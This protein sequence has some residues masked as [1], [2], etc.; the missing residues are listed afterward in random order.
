MTKNIMKTIGAMLIAVAV[1]L[2][3]TMGIT[4]YATSNT[5]SLGASITNVQ[6]ASPVATAT[7]TVTAEEAKEATATETE[8]E[9]EEVVIPQNNTVVVNGKITKSTLDGHY[10]AYSIPGLAVV[11]SLADMQKQAN[12]MVLEYFFVSTWDLYKYTAPAAVE[13]MEIVAQSE[14]AAL[15]ATFQMT[16]S[17][18][19]SM[20]VYPFEND[21]MQ[22]TTKVSIPTA[23]R[24]ENNT[25]AMVCVR[26]GGAFE[27]LPDLDDEP[28]TVTFNAHAG[29][30]AYGIIKY[31][32]K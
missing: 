5:G 4:A 25:Y 7:T 15:G 13:T 18:Y 31:L 8:Q 3:G 16:V 2:S 21:E 29:T 6:E 30:A 32:D 9:K 14:N 23:F 17:R 22:V 11:S 20:K 1:T 24:S 19:F 12:F 26:N 27:I 10:Y 28:T